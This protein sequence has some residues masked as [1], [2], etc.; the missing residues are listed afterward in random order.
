LSSDGKALAVVDS[1]QSVRLWDTET[2]WTLGPPVAHLADIADLT[3]TADGGTLVTATRAG[4]VFRFSV[5]R[6][7]SGSV[8]DCTTAIQQRL[9]MAT[10]SGELVLMKP[11]EW[12]ALETSRTE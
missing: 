10:R 7:M 3:F 5:P 11:Q 12:R 6:P 9:G 1:D 4:Q 8:R 2:G